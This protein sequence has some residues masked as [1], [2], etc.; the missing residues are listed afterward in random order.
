MLKAAIGYLLVKRE[1]VEEKVSDSGIVYDEDVNTDAKV[2]CGIC[3]SVSRGECRP[4]KKVYYLTKEVVQVE[5]YDS[6]PE[7]QVIAI[8]GDK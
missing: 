2:A 7:T 5:E 3:F 6:V 1:K 4:G 8:V